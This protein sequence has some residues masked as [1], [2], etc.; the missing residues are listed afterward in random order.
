MLLRPET[1]QPLREGD[2]VKIKR[3]SLI[4]G[5]LLWPPRSLLVGK[6]STL[7]FSFSSAR[8]FPFPLFYFF[9]NLS[10][11]RKITK[12]SSRKVLSS[13]GRSKKMLSS[14]EWVLI[15]IHPILSHLYSSIW[16]DS[17]LNICAKEMWLAAVWAIV[18]KWA[19]YL[20]D[21]E[22][23]TLINRAFGALIKS[24]AGSCTQAMRLLKF[25]KSTKKI[26]QHFCLPVRSWWHI[27]VYMRVC[28]C[29]HIHIYK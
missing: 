9:Y 21:P 11:E 18:D 13:S 4:R 28:V 23:S 26:N 24:I 20:A 3:R 6:T 25:L 14:W 12:S 1:G 5:K 8:R 29:A 19:F 22:P 27:Y 2:P 17:F 15:Y 7:P 16:P 10:P